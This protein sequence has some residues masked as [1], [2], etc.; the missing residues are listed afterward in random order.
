[1]KRTH[2]TSQE[3]QFAAVV[4]PTAEQEKHLE[5][6]NRC[7]GRVGARKILSLLERPIPGAALLTHPKRQKKA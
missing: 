2:L 4:G 7:R 6:C 3:V 1:M 5:K